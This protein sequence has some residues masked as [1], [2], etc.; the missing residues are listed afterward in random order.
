MFIVFE[1]VDWSW[2][3]TQLN[4][5]FEYLWKK[6]KYLQIWKTKEPTSNTESW[7][8]IT[9]KLKNWW[10]A[11]PQE[12]LDLYV[13][14]RKEQTL[15]RKQILKHSVILSSRFDYSTY[16][17]Q[18]VSWLSFDSIYKAHDDYKDILE[19]D[20]TFVF[21]LDKK[22]IDERLKKRWED[23]ECFENIDFLDKVNQK[24]INISKKLKELRNRNIYL[25]DANWD[26]EKTFDKVKEVL[27][28]YF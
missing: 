11:S 14:D 2:K 10:F 3:D 25:I 6:N 16:A 8:K 22:N 27:D 20:L 19:P 15:I 9:Y 5:T 13:Q 1:W 24:Y 4:K 26:I 23:R 21:Y 17:Y 18:W 28:K 7:R 12:A